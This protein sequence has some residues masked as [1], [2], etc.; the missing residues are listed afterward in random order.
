MRCASLAKRGGVL[1]SAVE[2]A[3]KGYTGGWGLALIDLDCGASVLVRP[4]HSQYPAS[5]GKIMIVIAALRAVQDGVLAFSDIQEHVEIVLEHSIDF[6]ADAINVLVTPEQ[7]AAVLQRAG[8]SEDSRIEHSWRFAHFTPPDLARVWVSL[9]RGEQLDEE[10]TAYLLGL[11]VANGLPENFWP[12]PPDFGENGYE[13]GQKAG[14]WT[15]MVPIGYRVSAGFA[16]PEDGSGGGFVFAFL[17]EAAPADLAGD[18]RRPVFPLVRDFIVGE[19][20]RER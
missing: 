14:Y 8:V 17:I 12:F 11:A 18:W 2:K 5:A 16:R 6:N 1:A 4:G 20:E 7:V 9:V 3:M 10:R 13:Y 15:S 19:V